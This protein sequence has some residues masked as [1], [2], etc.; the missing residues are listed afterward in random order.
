[1]TAP[2][3]SRRASSWGRWILVALAALI[4]AT[5]VSTLLLLQ[6]APSSPSA[7]AAEPFEPPASPDDSAA[8]VRAEMRNVDYHV[9][10][11]IVLHIR[12]L[13]GE[14]IPAE[15]VLRTFRD[16]D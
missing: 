16:T 4:G 15:D 7:D 1:M 5:L 14:L 6:C 8:T 13:R 2:G 3:T 9:D 10:P 12:Y 11:D